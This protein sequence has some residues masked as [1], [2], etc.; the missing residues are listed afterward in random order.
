M[1]WPIQF[2]ASFVRVLRKMKQWKN[3]FSYNLERYTKKPSFT[4]ASF[5]KIWFNDSCNKDGMSPYQG[6]VFLLLRWRMR[7]A[8]LLSSQSI[9]FS[10]EGDGGRE[11]E[12]VCRQSEQHD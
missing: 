6:L 4:L 1:I 12:Q 3:K 9:Q 11:K 10:R 7:W 5:F 8:W 2:F